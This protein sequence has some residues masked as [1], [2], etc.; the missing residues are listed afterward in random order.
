MKRRPR[1]DAIV[2]GS[3]MT[4]GWAA[5]ELTEHGLNT[6]V[7]EAGRIVDRE[8]LPLRIGIRQQLAEQ[9]RLLVRRHRVDQRCGNLL[10][11]LLDD[12]E[13]VP[14]ELR[15]VE[16]LHREIEGQRRHHL[17]RGVRVERP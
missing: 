17:R 14:L 3:G 13:A 2:V 6:L 4:G 5:K 12:V 15:L 9:V 8:A 10:T 11:H 7:L 1:Y 16:H